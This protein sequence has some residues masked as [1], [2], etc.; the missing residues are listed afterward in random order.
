MDK[1]WLNKY[2]ADVP[3][4]IDEDKFTSILDII[5]HSC[6]KHADAIAF[7][8]MG[9]RITFQELEV[10]SRHFASYLQQDLQLKPGDRCAIMMPNLIQ[11]PVALFGILRAGLIAVNVNPLYTQRELSHQLADSGAK[12]IITITNF[13]ANVEKVLPHTQ[14][15]HVILSK[16]ADHQPLIKRTA[17]NL[18]IKYVKKLVPAFSLPQAHQYLNVLDKGAK[19]TYH[20]PVCQKSDIAYLQYTGGTTGLAKGAILTHGNIVA[21]VL[22]VFDQFSPRTLLSKDKVVTPLPLYHIFANSVSLMFI[23][24]IGGQNLLITNPR[25]LPSFVKE[26]ANYPFT[27]FFGL[28][29]LFNGLLKNDAFKQIDFSHARFTIAGGMATQESIARDWQKVTGMP[30]IEGYGLTE[31]SPVVCS[32][33]HTQQ[34]YTAGIGVPL[35]S[36]EVRVVDE[37]QNPLAVDQVGELQIRGPQ[38]MQ[39]Y[40]QQPEATDKAISAD[41]WFTTGDLAKMDKN[42]C[43]YIVDRK[44]DMI[45]VSGFNVYPS[46]IE[47]VL[48]M[49]PE[50]EEAA[51]IG[52]ADPA[53]GEAIK[54]FI[55]CKNAELDKQQVIKHCRQYL[56]GYK[57]P[58]QIE[59]R[60]S[61]PK[62][63]VGKVLKRQLN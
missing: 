6:E 35:P 59:F 5:E 57:V 14:I 7:V 13:A 29:T 46:E 10:Q 45:L 30:V 37:E 11:Y 53:M 28:N 54:V 3:E 16:L 39:A 33:I 49:H 40:W 47:E 20:R 31:C 24:M 17:M 22:Q 21:N 58:K 4:F 23:M 36:T 63:N 48:T 1:I 43:F 15:E 27:I 2:P 26:L 12:M 41:G 9:A 34:E 52:I 60:A 56:T 19:H 62:S 8:N 51:A 18:A 55:C 50:I 32:G 38:V 25:D 61:L 44:K 42:G